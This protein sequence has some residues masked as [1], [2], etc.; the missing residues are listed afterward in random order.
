M[1]RE[2][3]LQAISHYPA[4]AQRNMGNTHK[5]TFGTL[6][7]IG[8]SEGMSGAI[9]LAGKS[10][11]KAGCG[12]VFLG[13]AQPQLPL[14]FIDSAPELMLQTAITL[15]E[16]PQISAWA[17]GCGL[18]LSP[19]SEQL[20]TTVLAQ[21][22]EKIPYVFDADAL[23][24]LAQLNLSHINTK[25]TANCV[26]TP[27]P[28]EAATLLHCDV[29]DIQN[30]RQQATI[31]ITRQY[32]CWAIVKGQGTVIASPQGDIT[33]NTTGNSGL[34]TAGSGDVLTGVMASFL[35][36]GMPIAE[37]V[38]S[39]VWIHGI[40]ADQLIKQGIGPIG[41]TAS[42]LIDTIRAVRNQ[43]WATHQQHSADLF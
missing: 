4:L 11:L 37:A 30:N 28:K 12:K 2:Q 31:E 8:S 23:V 18:G 29:A 1:N 41:L 22:N 26:L 3:L 16:Q 10:A 19:D 35:A 34:S 32:H 20:L 7:I 24:L 27:H 5:G 14:P 17:I 21:R 42:E 15:L 43:M 33:V 6:A 39:A 38:P 9:V 25:L 40:A 36:Q 13:F